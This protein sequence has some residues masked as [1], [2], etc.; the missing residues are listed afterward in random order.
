MKF[1]W[2][3]LGNRAI[4]EI[5]ILKWVAKLIFSKAIIWKIFGSCHLTDCFSGQK[6]HQNLGWRIGKFQYYSVWKFQNYVMGKNS[7][8][9]LP[10]FQKDIIHRC[11]ILIC[12]I[13]FHLFLSIGNGT[14]L[15]ESI[16]RWDRAAI[17][18]FL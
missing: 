6:K 15:A 7:N 3:K 16:I 17:L 1:L 12:V 11:I 2:E 4:F 9:H 13:N 8:K 18:C 14:G 5:V 10:L